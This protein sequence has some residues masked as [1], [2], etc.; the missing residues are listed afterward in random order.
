MKNMIRKE[1][2]NKRKKMMKWSYYE[3]QI[4]FYHYKTQSKIDISY[5]WRFLDLLVQKI[6]YKS[7]KR[8]FPQK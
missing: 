1:K 2:K 3:L 8:Y 6:K 5:S 7:A 4:I